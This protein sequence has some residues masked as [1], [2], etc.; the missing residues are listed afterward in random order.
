MAGKADPFAAAAEFVGAYHATLP[1]AAAELEVVADLVATRHLITVL[2][3]EWRAA[4]Y[5]ENRAYIM[6]HNP[7][8]WQALEHMADLSRNE[9]RDRLLTHLT[10]G[11]FR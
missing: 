9:S 10:T 5:A 2:I 3:S 8:A 6:R 7:G 1:L 4:R 11:D